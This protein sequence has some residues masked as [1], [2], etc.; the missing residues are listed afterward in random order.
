MNRS[1]TVGIDEFDQ[2]FSRIDE[3]T[4]KPGKYLRNFYLIGLNGI[5][6]CIIDKIS[7]RSL[8][9]YIEFFRQKGVIDQTRARERCAINGKMYSWLVKIFTD[10]PMLQVI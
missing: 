2:G 10:N 1:I 7:C 9:L 6:L 3:V 5:S 4:F 8:Q